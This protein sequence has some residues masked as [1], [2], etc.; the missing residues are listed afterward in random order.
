MSSR[1]QQQQLASRSRSRSSASLSHEAGELSSS[2]LSSSSASAGD[3]EDCPPLVLFK[4]SFRNVVYDVMSGRE[5]WAETSSDTDWDFNWSDIGW[6]RDF[7]DHI[8]FDDRQ[9]VNHFRNHYELTR[10][11]LLIKNLKR[12]KRQLQRSEPAEARCYDFFPSTYVLPQEYSLFLE[13]FKKSDGDT[14]I[15]KPIGSAQGKGIFLF[16]KLS[17][18]SEWKRDHTW[19]NAGP[20]PDTYVAQWYVR[21][22][23]TVGGRKFDLRLYVLVTSYSPLEVWVHRTG[24]CRFSSTRYSDEG[25][26]KDAY[27]HLTNHSVQKHA[28]GYSSKHDMK[29][30]VHDLRVH[31]TMKNG[32]DKVDRLFRDIQLMIVRS[33]LAVQQ[34][35]IHDK[36]SFEMYG[37]DVIFDEDF[38]PWLLEVNASP[39]VSG[40]SD[41]DYQLK[42]DVL[43]DLVDVVDV[44]GKRSGDETSVRGFDVVYRNGA[45]ATQESKIGCF[46]P[47]NFQA[48]PKKKQKPL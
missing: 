28:E 25:D 7:Y 14:W 48:R 36:H 19:T 15:M 23:Y 2:S 30:G 18:V 9:K 43:N 17:Q 27:M 42:Y 22:P 40:S 37:Y 39:S 41:D 29:L 20:Q 12:M 1:R 8:Q 11:D 33:L 5:G 32:R 47:S 21:R 31:M 4:S 13:E 10:K 6:V 34:A 44:E 35:I 16:N 45:Y 46:Y 38:K 26:L 3:D 24:F